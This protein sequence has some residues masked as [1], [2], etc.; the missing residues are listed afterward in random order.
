MV[1][2]ARF[3]MVHL[4][5]VEKSTWN[6]QSK[7][8]KINCEVQGYFTR[9]LWGSRRRINGYIRKFKRLLSEDELENEVTQSDEIDMNITLGK[10][11]ISKGLKSKKSKDKELESSYTAVVKALGMK[12]PKFTSTTFNGDPLEWSS[13]I[14]TFD[15]AVVSRESV[16]TIEKFSYL[17]G[18]LEES[19]A[20]C[21]RDF[22]LVSKNYVE[23]RKLLKG[24]FGN[25]QVII[26]AL[27]SDL[28]KLPKLNNNN[29][30]K[31]TSFYNAFNS[32]LQ[33]LMTMGLN[34]SHYGPLLIPVILERL[35]DSITLIV[36]RKLRKKNWH[37][38]DFMNWIKKEV[39]ARENCNFIK[40]KN[41]YEN[42]RNTTHSL[43]GVH[44]YLRKNWVFCRK[45]Y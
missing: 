43:L 23:S 20:G 39:D 31:Q 10:Q 21:V 3:E 29:V 2:R 26:S 44:K 17:T 42:L 34:Y 14:G 33:S 24:K 22:S 12:L 38:S 45:L 13:F 8:I 28:L 40:N 16:S 25:M 7:C 18:H 35:P 19:A 41:D 37:I 1:S 15:A 30:V 4:K 11:K 6:N 9:K 27:M 36:K 5:K 32:N